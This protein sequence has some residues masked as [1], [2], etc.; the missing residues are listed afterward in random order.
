M[1]PSARLTIKKSTHTGP[2]SGP[3]STPMTVKTSNG[4]KSAHKRA[5]A[6]KLQ[7]LGLIIDHLVAALGSDP[8]ST[9]RR[10]AILADIDEYPGTTQAE[11]MDRLD[12]NKSA[13]NRDIDWLHD[14]GCILRQPGTTDG[15]VIHLETCGYA[16]K[17]LSLA[18]DYVGN[19]H[20]K[21]K[22]LL[23]GIINVFPDRKPT[24]RDA[25]LLTTMA[26]LGK[27]SR[28]ELFGR[29][30]SASAT[31]NARTLDSLI[32]EG[33]ITRIGTDA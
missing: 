10:A 23:E 21:L 28:Q 32:E 18:L 19:S 12:L 9:V 2:E 31:T 22:T 15:R 11:V 30:C 1:K 17:N 16:K 6:S 20:K 25:R 14:H 33:L 7:Q 29:S 13:L 3:A 27:A 24:L 26:E 4:L 8:S 5:S